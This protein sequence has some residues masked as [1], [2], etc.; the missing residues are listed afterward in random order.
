MNN[1]F[2]ATLVFFLFSV[3]SYSEP[4][5]RNELEGVR[6]VE[7]LGDPVDLNTNFVDE[8]GQTVALMDYVK[9]GPTVIMFGYL[10]CPKLCSL[11][12]NG[13]FGAARNLTWSLGKEYNF[14]MIS[15]DPKED[16][17]LAANK[18]VNYVRYYGRNDSEKGIHFLTGK[19]ANI[20]KLANE[21]GFQ[22]RYDEKAKQY[23]H[24][25]VLA[26]ISPKGKFTSDQNASK[27]MIT[28]YLYGIDFQ[29]HDLKLALIEASE[30]RIGNIV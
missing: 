4:L 25:A 28:R 2:L 22:Y 9:D 11:V 18:K 1:R 14:V 23:V 29:S 12:A 15:I 30:G 27:G 3:T 10:E 7:H 5:G 24:P 13:F 6:V 20:R 21:V 8:N 16:H 26:V 19:E 17:I